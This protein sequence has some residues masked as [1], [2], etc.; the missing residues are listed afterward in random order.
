MLNQLS[1]RCVVTI[2]IHAAT[3]PFFISKPIILLL[4]GVS[5]V[6]AVIKE[7]KQRRRLR[8]RKRQS[9]I[10]LN[11][12]A[13]ILQ[14]FR[15]V[16]LVQ[17]RRTTETKKSVCMIIELN[18]RRPPFHCLGTTTSSPW[19]SLYRIFCKYNTTCTRSNNREI[20]NK[21]QALFWSDVFVAIAVAV[22]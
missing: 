2:T 10:W 21:L 11:A 3:C 1:H 8:Q 7:F 13:R 17:Y 12:I 16:H 6:V 22:S 20:L 14:L 4:L 5:V 9:K 15:L 19:L 18:S